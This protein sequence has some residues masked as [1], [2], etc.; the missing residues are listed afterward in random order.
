[1]RNRKTL[2]RPVSFAGRGLHTGE[3]ASITLRPY[4]GQ[5][6]IVS[7][8]DES[9]PLE[10]AEFSG[11]ARGTVLHFPGGKELGTVEHLLS[12][13]RGSDIDDVQICVE[14]GREVPSMDGSAAAFADHFSESGIVEK[15]EYVTPLTLPYPVGIDTLDNGSSIMAFPS[16]SFSVTYVIDYPG[17]VIG[18]GMKTLD[19]DPE[20]YSLEIAA[21]R[22]FALEKDLEE[23]KRR[24]LARGG[25]LSNAVL[26]RETEALAHGGLRFHDEFVRHKILDLTGD[27]AILNRSICFHVVC[28]RGGHK[29]H[30]ELVRKLRRIRAI[31]V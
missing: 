20:N 21:A 17:S 19:I 31:T 15:E 18:T 29:L 10:M 7:F 3:N 25:D 11:D 8:P 4:D 30:L 13:L 27:L 28:I 1:M 23:L 6:Y 22:T 9:F 5:G 16:S 14:K 24:G 2:A 26:V 12:A